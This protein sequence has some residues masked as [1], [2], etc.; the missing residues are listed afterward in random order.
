MTLIL[1][2]RDVIDLLDVDR[3]IAA[4]RE[5]FRLDADRQTIAAGVLGFHAAD[6]GFHFKGAGILRDRTW[7]AGKLNANFPANPPRFGLPTIQGVVILCDGETGS[8]LALMDSSALT[9]M[10][11]GAATAVAAEHLARADSRVATIC[12]CGV[13]GRSQL[14][15]V[16][17]VRPIDRVLVF[18][19]DEDRSHTFA[20]EMS[21]DSGIDV[22]PAS[23]LGQAVR[24]SDV[25]ITCTPSRRPLL[26]PGDVSPGTFIAAVGADAPGKQ[27]LDSALMAAAT[28]VV[29]HLE[30]CATLGS[31]ATPWRPV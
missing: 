30:Q 2:R 19:V 31:C 22:R 4:V 29:D 10:R 6:G 9:A 13:Q 25:C 7:F 14:R 16:C 27:E 21:D 18:D 26:R 28:I 24:K 5:A 23:D 3:C 8:P 12:G 11:T 1:T 20:R 17:R 15:A